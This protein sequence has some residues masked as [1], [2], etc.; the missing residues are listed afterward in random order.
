MTYTIIFLTL[1]VTIAALRNRTLFNRL[2]LIP[3]RVN[4][5]REWWRVIT[6][7][8]V[9]ADY[10]HLAV[11]M[12]VLLSFGQFIE[13]FFDAYTQ[14]G[15]ISNGDAWYLLLY[16]GGMICASIYDLV[17]YR[18]NP[19]YASIGAS[20]AVAAVVFTSIF[21]NPWGKLYLLGIIPIP[22]IIFGLLY[23]GYSSYMGRRQGERINHFAHLFGA[24][25][26]FLFPLLM[27]T[28]FCS[29]FWQNLVGGR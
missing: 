29:L 6:H 10:I 12:V 21:F 24:L 15:L 3:Y 13:Q 22:G 25:Y 17:R 19:A 23:I 14:I 9:H 11:N 1:I 26:G 5:N 18:N 27:D 7:G 28:N 16:F 4:H 20:G 8:F 2:A